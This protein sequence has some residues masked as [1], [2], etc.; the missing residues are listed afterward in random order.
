M[1]RDADMATRDYLTLVLREIGR[2]T[3]IGV[4]QMV[5]GQLK[6]ALDQYADPTFRPI[7]LQ[8]L[9]DGAWTHVQDTSGG[10]DPQLAW[11]R[12]FAAAAT[13]APDLVRL[14]GLLSGD[15]VVEGLNVDTDLRWHLL[16]NLVAR[17]GAGGQDI[18]AELERDP[19]AAGERNAAACRAAQPT[20]EAKAAAWVSIVERDALPN[21]VQAAVI[22][23]FQQPDQRTLLE[24]YVE[25]Y[26]AAVEE[27][28]ATRTRETA[29]RLTEGL[30]PRYVIDPATVAT[31]N[32][33]IDSEQ[34]TSGLR[35]LLLE[36]ADAMA[37]ALRARERD[38]AA[39]R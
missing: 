27:I 18:D 6:V 4:I 12:T 2:E 32:Q 26:L 29:Q 9:T 28:W 33:F 7:G 30:F 20:A 23:G 1:T 16:F 14:R 3:D 22:R 39:A 31:V 36:R 34:P 35:R 21:A 25:R 10:S 11:V 19:T 8:W 38:A 5:L 24:P 13:S 15:L 37:R 17:A